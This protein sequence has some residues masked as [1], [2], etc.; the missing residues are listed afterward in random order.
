M[1]FNLPCNLYMLHSAI[2]NIQWGGIAFP[3]VL[4]QQRQL[5]SS[6]TVT[7]V[8]PSLTPL[9]SVIRTVWVLVRRERQQGKSGSP[10]RGRHSQRQSYTVPVS[11]QRGVLPPGYWGLHERASSS[12]SSI[13]TTRIA[14]FRAWS[15]G[16]PACNLR[17]VRNAAPGELG[18]RWDAS[19]VSAVH[20][21]NYTG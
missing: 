11:Q 3:L 9:N 18:K 4:S 2:K 13:S 20:K 14:P 21:H 19:D 17:C 16:G 5:F 8:W 6:F 1:A 7:R 10:S 15:W 12:S